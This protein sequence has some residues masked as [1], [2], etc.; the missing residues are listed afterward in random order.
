MSGQQK[1]IE[2]TVDV[3][4]KKQQR[5]RALP[6]LKPP[7]LIQA[8]LQE[9]RELE[10]LGN[11]PAHYRL[12]TSAR[13]KALESDLEMAGQLPTD[14]RLVLQERELA[15]DEMPDGTNRPSR[16]LYLRE[17]ASGAVYR[18]HHVPAIIGRPDQNQPRDDWLAVN[19]QPY[20]SGLRVSRRQAVIVEEEGRFYISSLSRNPTLIRRESGEVVPVNEQRHPIDSGDLVILERSRIMLKVLVRTDLDGGL[21]ASKNGQQIEELPDAPMEEVD[22][23]DDDAPGK[24]GNTRMAADPLIE[25]ETADDNEKGT[26]NGR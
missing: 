25:A 4:E 19:L 2:L 18:L 17:V 15:G 8:I 7:E 24:K 9:F 11:D 16:P 23:G 26:S 20:K 1:R 13:D 6:A 21:A 14:R 12:F 22:A 3:F 5:A 10:Y